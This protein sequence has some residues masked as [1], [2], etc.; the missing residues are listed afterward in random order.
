M[1]LEIDKNNYSEFVDKIVDIFRLSIKTSSILFNLK[2]SDYKAYINLSIV[3][4]SG[5]KKEYNEVI[6]DYND[7]FYNDFLLPLISKVNMFGNIVTK[8]IVNL[9]NDSLVTLRFICENNDLF[10]IDGL[11]QNDSNNLM[12]LLD[13]KKN[14]LIEN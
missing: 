8:D 9:D 3:E 14:N 13:N 7:R 11:S 4:H 2:I 12:K 5:E 6:L 1:N 10:T